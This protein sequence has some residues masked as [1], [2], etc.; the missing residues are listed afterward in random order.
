MLRPL[1]RDNLPLLSFNNACANRQG[2]VVLSHDIAESRS[3]TE[4]SADRF[5]WPISSVGSSA[6]CQE[7]TLLTQTQ[8]ANGL[9]GSPGATFLGDNQLETF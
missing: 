4:M 1:Q 7:R 2:A 3:C 6:S 5:Q 9:S 8:P